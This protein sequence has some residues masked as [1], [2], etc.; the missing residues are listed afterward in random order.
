MIPGSSSGYARSNLSVGAALLTIE[1]N[2]RDAY[3]GQ[4]IL[5]KTRFPEM[6]FPRMITDK[7]TSSKTLDGIDFLPWQTCT[8]ETTIEKP[9]NPDNPGLKIGFFSPSPTVSMHPVSRLPP[10]AKSVGILTGQGL[11]LATAQRTFA[12]Q[13]HFYAKSTEAGKES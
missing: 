5:L 10:A 2:I 7:D 1:V 12:Y 11:S 6:I 13:V 4:L 3:P 9:D 8:F